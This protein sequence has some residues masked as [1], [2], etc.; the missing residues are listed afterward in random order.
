MRHPHVLLT[1]AVLAAVSLSGCSGPATSTTS[2]TAP[3][4]ATA[5]PQVTS[6]PHGTSSPQ[7]SEQPTAEPGAPSPPPGG[8]RFTIDDAQR[9]V[10]TDAALDAVG[11]T[12][13]GMGLGTGRDVATLR[14]T[15]EKKSLAVSRATF[16]PG[17]EDACSVLVG[18]ILV[19]L[20]RDSASPELDQSTVVPMN[21]GT[22][23]NS[24][25]DIT[26][27]QGSRVFATDADADA[28]L[29]AIEAALPGCPNGWASGGHS[30][31]ALAEPIYYDLP[32]GR[33]FGVDG[34]IV[35]VAVGNI[36]TAIR[37]PPKLVGD[38]RATVV[39]LAADTIDALG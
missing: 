10:V 3:N 33:A 26:L 20:A 15:V 23:E 38:Q 27:W 14:E 12:F 5:A 11:L 8:G 6:S 4:P 2:T 9:G 13:V 18:N 37:F 32:N 7:A 17:D 36:V 35:V 29:D 1:I 21:M 19:N 34:S 24:G 31:E 22:D 30:Y 16:Q 39:G 25:R 28:H